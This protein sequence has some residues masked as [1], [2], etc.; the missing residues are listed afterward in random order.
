MKVP[1]YGRL[2]QAGGLS[3]IQQAMGY[4]LSQAGVSCCIIP[5]DSVQQLEENVKVASSF[6]Q[7]NNQQLAEIEQKTAN[8]W[9]DST[10]YRAWG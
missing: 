1:A 2:F 8:I 5:A 7:L 9:Q 10:F 6:Q 3:G 4:S